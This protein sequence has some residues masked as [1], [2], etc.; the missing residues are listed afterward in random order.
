MEGRP[1]ITVREI[2]NRYEMSLDTVHRWVRGPGWQEAVVGKRGAAKEFDPTL[3]DS[4]VRERIWLPPR[5][6]SVP[7][8]ALLTLMEIS[9]YTGI[10]YEDVK[11][12]ATDVSGRGSVLGEADDSDGSRR[13]WKRETVDERV[14]GRQKRRSRTQ[15]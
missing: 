3:V 7:A 1:G 2:A 6:T 11:H 9:E 4:L 13:L 14:R 10:R 5:E 15:G 12:M 8:G